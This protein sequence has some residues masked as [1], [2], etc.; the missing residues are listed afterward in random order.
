MF[1]GPFLFSSIHNCIEHFNNSRDREKKEKFA[2][3][4]SCKAVMKQYIAVVWEMSLLRP[5][6]VSE[7]LYQ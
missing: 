3:I 1:F 2:E 5:N 7:K 6:H 4:F